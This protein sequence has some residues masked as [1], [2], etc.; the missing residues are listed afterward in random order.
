MMRW[1]GEFEQYRES[2]LH[3]AASLRARSR[4][5]GR[6]LSLLNSQ[7]QASEL[8]LPSTPR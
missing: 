8:K 7:R 2:S 3:Q 6:R 4:L 1:L 5:E